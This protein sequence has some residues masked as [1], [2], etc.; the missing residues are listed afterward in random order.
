MCA[1][2]YEIL[3][4]LPKHGVGA[5]LKREKWMNDSFWEITKVKMDQN[6]ASG[7]S[8]GLLTWRGNRQNEEPKRINGSLKK[9]WKLLPADKEMPSWPSL[10]KDLM[11]GVA[12]GAAGHAVGKE[13]EGD[14]LREEKQEKAN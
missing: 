14:V 2:V 13:E 12:Q 11:E 6:G 4:K 7:K 10:P 3:S 9:L 8:Y 5:K 1:A